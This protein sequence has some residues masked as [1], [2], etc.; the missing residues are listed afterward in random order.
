MTEREALLRAVCESPDDD[1]PRLVFAD[2]L[3]ENG[4]AERAEFIRA[5]I[6][7]DRQPGYPDDFGIEY[8]RL[9]DKLT[10]Y[11]SKWEWRRELAIYGDVEVVWRR[12]FAE[13]IRCDTQEWLGSAAAVLSSHPVR[14]VEFIDAEDAAYIELIHEYGDPI[15]WRLC[16]HRSFGDLA[17]SAVWRVGD[18]DTLVAGCAE[19]IAEWLQDNADPFIDSDP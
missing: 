5:E 6:E 15:T 11:L 14:T 17:L 16:L 18:R 7:L 1:V 9:N 3:E 8:E 19:K 12:G 10:A 2:W 13:I 4:E